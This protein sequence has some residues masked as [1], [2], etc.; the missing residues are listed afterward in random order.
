MPSYPT[1]RRLA[2]THTS[3]I[4]EQAGRPLPDQLTH[5][6][7]FLRHTYQAFVR[8]AEEEPLPAS[9]AAEWVLDNFYVV[10]QAI[11]Q[12]EE[13]LPPTYYRE[14]P[15]LEHT[16]LA[17]YPRVYG[18]ARHILARVD[19]RLDIEQA[20][21]F[22][23]AYQEVTPLT[24]GE[25]WAM[26]IML[27]VATLENLS[28]VLAYVLDEP[29][30]DE[31]RP[32]V[33]VSDQ[34]NPDI[35]TANCI[36]S[37]R[38]LQTHDWQTFFERVSLVEQTLNRD[39]AQVYEYM[40]F[41]TR[42]RY[43]KAVERLSRTAGAGE[44][45]VAQ[46]A[47]RLA[48]EN[49]T[50]SRQTHVGY[51]LIDEGLAQ[52][53][54]E[55]G[56]QPEVT[57]LLHRW[58]FR[59]H[60][61]FTY[62]GG[63]SLLTLLALLVP[64][65]YATAAGASAWQITVVALMGLIPASAIAIN[66]INWLI[67]RLVSPRILPKM[68][69][70]EAIPADARTVVVVPALFTN[71]EDVN[72]LL[73][74]LELHYL[75]NTDP[76]LSFALLTDFADAP[77]K[78]MPDDEALL[79]QAQ[80]GI[81]ALNEQYPDTPFYLFHRDRLWNPQEE[82]WM[83]WERKRGKLEEFNQMLL[84]Q[85]E[86]SYAVQIGD[87]NILPHI[88]YIITLDA[89]TV[90]PRGSAHRLI[91]A[92]AHPLN[93]PCLDPVSGRLTAGYTVLQP[94]TETKPVSAN[95]SLFSR[96]FDGE[97]GFDL[98]THAVSDVYQDLFGEG[99]YTGKGIYDLKAFV[100]SLAGRVPENAL[101][102]HDL[103]E[104]IH[105]RAAL[106]SDIT[107][108][109]EYP[110]NYLA[111]A[112]RLHRW[113]RGDWQ[114][115]PWLIPR[116]PHRQPESVP[117]PLSPID[118]WKVV[119]NMRRSL[120]APILLAWLIV[121]WLWLPG[122]PLFWTAIIILVPAITLFSHLAGRMA[123][124]LRA[125][126]RGASL[127]PTIR[128][129]GLHW[130]LS[131]TFLPYEALITVDAIATVF[132]RLFI[133]KKRL[134]QWTTAAHTIRLFGKQ[135]K[136]ALFWQQMAGAPLLALGLAG[137]LLW[138]NPVALPIALP[139]LIAWLLS[140]QIALRISRP[141]S[142]EP[143]ALTAAQ[144][145]ELH[146]L[147][148]V[149][150]HFFEQFVGPEDH[151]LPPD[152]FQEA[153]RGVVAHRTSPTNIGLML[154]S[155]LGAFDL[156]Y[157]GLRDLAFRLQNSFDSLDSLERHRGH[158]LNW[159]DTRTKMPLPPRY[160]STV[161]SGNLVGSLIALRQG[162]L[163]MPDLSLPRWAR[164]QGLL[165]TIGVLDD[166]VSQAAL[167]APEQTTVVR[168]QIHDICQ[169]IQDGREEPDTWFDLW[170][171]I[172][173][174]DWP[175]LAQNLATLAAVEHPDATFLHRIRHWSER[176]GHHL[177]T[178]QRQLGT[179][180]PWL[181]ALRA[182]P[183]LFRLAE[184][185]SP[186]AATWDRVTET[187]PIPVR[188][189]Q[190]PDVCQKAKTELAHLRQQLSETE[191]AQDEIK[192]AQQWCDSLIDEL[193]I[194]GATATDMLNQY[195]S[196]SQWIERTIQGMPFDFLYDRQ[197]HVFHIG[198]QVDA[199]KTDPN[200]YDLLASEARIA[201]LIAIARGDVPQRHWLHLG[202]PL[203]ELN[204]KRFLLS[205]SAT[206]FEYLMPLM[207]MRQYQQT[208]LD[209]SM[210]SAVDRQ[211]AYARQQDAP[212]GIS[213]SGYYRFDAQLNY[214]YRAFGV[215][216]LGFKR[217][218][219]DDLVI[220]PYASL[221][222]LPLRPQAVM[223]NIGRLR[224]LDMLG[225]YG[226]YE[227]IDY[228]TRRLPLGQENA[229]VRSFMVHHQGM[230]F[231]SLL[232]TLAA[233]PMVRR[234]HAD[235]RI[236]SV[237]MLL[238]EQIPQGAPLTEKREAEAAPLHMAEPEVTAVPWTVPTQTPFPQIH[239]LSNGRYGLLITNAGGGYSRW[240]ETDLT[241]WRADT[242]SDDWGTW[243]YLQ[244]RESGQLRLVGRQPCGGEED[245]EIL[246]ASHQVVYRCAGD[247]IAVR[248]TITV[249]P[250]DDVEIRHLHLTNQSSRPRRLRLVSYGEIVLNRQ[251]ADQRHPV[252]NKL[253]IE[254]SYHAD[255]NTLLFSRRPRS[256]EEKPPFMA[257]LVV[258]QPGLEATGA[259]ET[260][261]DR[262]I[263]R[264]GSLRRP[265]ALA[266]AENGLSSS[267][268]ATLDPIMALEQEVDLPPYGS[269]E[270]AFLTLAAPTRDAAL[271]LARQ[272]QDWGRINHAI[273]QAQTRSELEMRQM[274]LDG[275]DMQRFQQLLSLLIY[276]HA[277]LRSRPELLAANEKGQPGLWPYAIS[278]DYPILLVQISRDEELGL[279]R[280][281][282][283]A[284][285]YWRN[286]G[287][288]IDL[289][290]MNMEESGYFQELQGR[291]HRLLSRMDSDDWLN[292][293]GG[294]FLLT[295]NTMSAAD[296]TLLLAAARVVLDGR[297]G[298][299]SAQLQNLLDQPI[300][301]PPLLSTNGN[302]KP[303]PTP[304]LDR[305]DDLLFDNGYGGFSADGL[306]YCIYLRPG[307]T[308]PAPWINVI[309]NESFG[310]MV[311]EAGSGNTWAVN[312]GENRLTPW[313]ND[314]VRD[315]PG[316][317]LYLRDE[318]TGDIWSPTPQPIG[319][320][321]PYLIRH[322]AG[323]TIFQHHS[324]G[325]KQRLRLFAAPEAPVKIVQLRLENVWN[326]PRRITATY[327][328]EWVL[329]VNRDEMQPYI[330]SEYDDATQSLLV[331]NPY[332]VE[333]GKRVAFAA[334]SEDLHGLTADRTEFLGR[335]GDVQE[336]AALNR[337]GLNS[338]VGAGLDPCAALQLHLDMEPGQLVEIYFFIG[339]GANRDEAIRL[340]ER[341]QNGGEVATAWEETGRRWDKLLNTVTVETPDEAMNLLLNRWLLY[342]N[343]S[344]RIWGR[345]AFYQSGGAYG[346]RDQLQDVMGVLHAAPEVARQQ[347]VRAARHQFEAGDVLHW[348][349]P[350]SGRGVRTRISD[351]LLWLPYVT[352]H[353]VQVTGDESVLHE[354][355]PFRK[356][357]PLSANEEE[358][359]A[360]YEL[361]K[362]SHTLYEHCCR[363]LEKGATAGAH[364]LPLMGGGDW[365][366]GMNR[367]GI[368]GKGESVWLG[369]FLYA[370]LQASIPL[371][372]QMDDEAR[373]TQFE[374]QAAKLRTALATHAWDGDWYLRA[375][376]D[377]GAP[378]GSA[379]NK[380]C[381]ID[382]IAQSW[383]VLSSAGDPDRMWQAM[384]AVQENLVQEAD[385]LIR[386]FTPPFDKTKRDPG[387]IKGYPPGIRENGGQYTHAA[388]W[389]VWAMAELGQGD[390]AEALFRLLNPIYHSDTP[391][392]AERYRVE[393]YVIAADVYGEQ[394][395][396][397]R[398][399]WTWYTGSGSWFYRLG[400]EA[401]LGLRLQGDTLRIAPCIP[402]GWNG[403][404]I[405]YLHGNT[406]YRIRVENPDGV[407]QNVQQVT[408]DGKSLLDGAIPLG[409]DG[410]QHDVRVRMGMEKGNE[411]DTST[412]RSIF[413]DPSIRRT[414]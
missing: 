241:R 52:L 147:A 287:L 43:R 268:E 223:E 283:Q 298:S 131:L 240:Q 310:F 129:Q 60:P 314:P 252:F 79:Q 55:I 273:S 209:Q 51:Y 45:A 178:I 395:F 318:E 96:I 377:D 203:T 307:Q 222:A 115:L 215:P 19:G 108:Y 58:L 345:S 2:Q 50:P 184:P 352:A 12:I 341:F 254:S 74:Q 373:A 8:E 107:L 412:N 333:F 250:E 258:P 255:V 231:I 244:D 13:G 150:W 204:G 118:Y 65:G 88:R 130:L 75:R 199:E 128:R 336:P 3:A 391:R 148:R 392:K 112:H 248:T 280:E 81:H 138:L 124:Q 365:N 182:T 401:I 28:H 369:W 4:P 322:G 207:L 308:T 208:L 343:F 297:Y 211:I 274:E 225:D 85:G 269:I 116:V 61:T 232:N 320:D 217:G 76:H 162:C 251:A 408:L 389:T 167:A 37:L 394:P 243:I 137:L 388:I 253:F 398:G 144:Q 368:E 201:S 67:S 206:M 366:D 311:S 26:P 399:G 82:A 97:S 64:L 406:T 229:R 390:L 367:V 31:K 15:K 405:T 168:D 92:L 16:S 344:C 127:W 224:D 189:R 94:R 155:T 220:S 235:R 48:Q 77:E 332:N 135:C 351:D 91:G 139:L 281:L 323:Y 103:F 161:D 126:K 36:L 356:G 294:I 358:R 172:S 136:L 14:L 278:G 396:T 267:A 306:E 93:R 387:Y 151:W 219:E 20:C 160:V 145:H 221:L 10:Q 360:H 299:L 338:N 312:S 282:L 63:I 42:D 242:T 327:Y 176:V 195:H 17:G 290:L 174:I 62:L 321:A 382:G 169:Q 152:H 246:F 230:I 149:T 239:Y 166:V 236:Q 210:H 117:N 140:P 177:F 98:Y 216:G 266:T 293:R 362:E 277:A 186:L 100:Q 27:R 226:F 5:Y 142:H 271:T 355:V 190:I 191:G 375:F 39:P 9:H 163:E 157:L 66:L 123:R 56:C 414:V 47:I 159:Y 331:R 357:E 29:P 386:L 340:V 212:W 315:Q 347:I 411:Y 303:Q 30:P 11:Y 381:R 363:A 104:G 120:L 70:A 164:W 284:H 317:A 33:S 342:Q 78:Q 194:A 402:Q 361:T 238:Q 101:L 403:F 296:Q 179:L 301:L 87:Q 385:G 270:I 305:P 196:L 171:Q 313:R 371:C 146:C 21:H 407:N 326:R 393:P 83:G 192:S 40:T 234:F 300:R 198:Y 413:S 105:G 349:H 106:V 245:R 156:G 181:I 73:R 111:Y 249:A 348:W 102:S 319:A 25:L 359:Y 304:P 379:Q 275:E 41:A 350:P 286:R 334:T 113:I 285:T 72:S 46:A 272:Y 404:T 410:A 218:L 397:G 59:R 384:V 53:E 378:L 213:E 335:L 328:A 187:L 90:L 337:V 185:G 316:E 125:D 259:Y 256:A 86:T 119:D 188:L 265:A 376:Y 247:E 409:N 165:D 68:D 353:Y 99:I 200:Y 34:L 400:L 18:V 175:Q 279:A 84:E 263:G 57:T 7:R 380:E 1:A 38:T 276:P 374:R 80:D 295:Y 173:E 134:L 89:D 114:L 237:E 95:A 383:S 71:Q 289:V 257:H 132:V 364:G 262:F 354:Q 309:A 291:L 202:R 288:Q 372:R 193:G 302:L 122:E 339:Q 325:L 324:H 69:F 292:R 180:V 44:V 205:W 183:T 141:I 153:P 49:D 143:A 264:Y 261:R 330:V 22:L 32:S 329:G 109:E 346:F 24:M 370:T 6:A 110:S 228:T 233:A 154:L 121:G 158:F 260:D 197:R 54:V 35:L 133:T 23:N 170:N 214:Q 227:A